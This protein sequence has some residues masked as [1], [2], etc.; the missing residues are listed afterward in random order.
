MADD[1]DEPAPHVTLERILVALGLSGR[2]ELEGPHREPLGAAARALW[3]ALPASLSEKESGFLAAADRLARD[4]A[5]IVR[6]LAYAQLAFA[7]GA[8]AENPD[9]SRGRRELGLQ[10][11][12]GFSAAVTDAAVR[13]AL[14]LDDRLRDLSD[15]PVVDPISSWTRSSS[16]AA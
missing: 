9:S 8:L 12:K 6:R 2:D 5:S 4:P 7:S 11:A 13:A 1:R 10:A 14:H 3:L 15:T 16:A